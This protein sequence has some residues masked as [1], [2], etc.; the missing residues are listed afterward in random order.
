MISKEYQIGVKPTPLQG[1]LGSFN[2][3]LQLEL[4]PSLATS[5]KRSVTTTAGIGFSLA[6]I[7]PEVS[8]V[9]LL[10]I[11]LQNLSSQDIYLFLIA[12]CAI[13]ALAFRS[14]S[15]PFLGL[16]QK[17]AN[18][19]LNTAW[20]NGDS[21]NRILQGRRKEVIRQ[22]YTWWAI[23]EFRIPVWLSAVAIAFMAYRIIEN[24]P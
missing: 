8:S 24:L 20:K 3:H 14:W 17:H 2:G 7:N 16:G 9:N 4:F 13:Q 11:E 19:V 10:G 5:K 12:A 22:R 6:W 15:Q 1:S 18:E 23:W 21:E